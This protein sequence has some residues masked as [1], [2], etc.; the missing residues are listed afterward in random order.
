MFQ[1]FQYL[2][3]IEDRLR[4]TGIATSGSEPSVIRL[5]V[6]LVFM[7]LFEEKKAIEGKGK[8][9]FQAKSFVEF[10]EAQEQSVKEGKRA[11]HKLFDQ[12]KNFKEFQETSLFT[13]YDHLPDKPD[14]PHSQ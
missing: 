3:R 7:K 14:F 6:Y 4:E 9:W 8:N 11:I 5:L 12:I 13:Q 1:H 10:Q 2:K